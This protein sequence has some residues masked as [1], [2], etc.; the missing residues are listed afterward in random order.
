MFVHL[1]LYRSNVNFTR[2]YLPECE[3][4]HIKMAYGGMQTSLIPMGHQD[5]LESAG[6]LVD[7]HLQDDRT[8]LDLSE[9]LRVPVHCMMFFHSTVN[10]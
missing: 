8:S 4:T 7:K 1:K 10:L 5:M 6:R 2:H 3:H 9:L